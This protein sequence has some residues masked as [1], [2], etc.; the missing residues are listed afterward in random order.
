MH[1]SLQEGWAT[2]MVTLRVGQVECV[3][4]LVDRGA[5]VNMAEEVSGVIIHC[6]HAMQ[7]V[8]SSG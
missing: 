7:H 8:R 3:K 2:L 5:E 6:V 4:L 1:I